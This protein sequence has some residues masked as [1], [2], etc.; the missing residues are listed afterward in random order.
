LPYHPSECFLDTLISYRISDT[1][2]HLLTLEGIVIDSSFNYF[3]DRKY[4]FGVENYDQKEN[5]KDQQNIE[6][7]TPEGNPLFLNEYDEYWKWGF[8]KSKSFFV[9]KKHGKWGVVDE[10]NKIVFSIS[11]NEIERESFFLK[12]TKNFQSFMIDFYGRIYQLN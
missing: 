5:D 8:Y 7:I 10:N 2:Y 11:Y 3:N 4:R 6:E 1:L 9:V 12:F